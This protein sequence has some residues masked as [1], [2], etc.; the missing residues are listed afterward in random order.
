MRLKTSLT[1]AF[2]AFSTACGDEAA[3]TTLQVADSSGVEVVTNLAGSTEAADLWSLSPQPAVNIGSDHTSGPALSRVTALA[4]LD[5]EEVVVGMTRPPQGLVIG[6]DGTV[7]ATLGRAGDGPGEFSGVASVVPL[8]GDSIAVWDQVRRRMS[9][10]SETGDFGRE[11]DLGPLAPAPLSMV[12]ESGQAYLLAGPD[13]SLVLFGLGVLSPEDGVHRVEA[14]SH[15]VTLDGRSLASFGPFPGVATFTGHQGG[16]WV[17]FGARS[18][19][20]TSGDRLI[21]GTAE[22]TEFAVF[23]PDGRLVR[24]VRWPDHD[25]SVVDAFEEDLSRFV[26]EELTAMPPSAG[27][28]VQTILEEAPRA[29]RYPAYD[30][31][32][33]D[34]NGSVWLAD[35]PGQLALPGVL[36]NRRRMPA[37]RWLVFGPDGAITAAVETPEGFEPYFVRDNAVWGVY[38]DELDVESVRAYQ[39]QK[40]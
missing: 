38:K 4:L 8:T 37:R 26:D 16:G 28:M 30:G 39:I 20:A 3:T 9:V 22:E 35:Y 33:A 31:L 6:S 12:V 27:T 36:P 1:V 11:V 10:F 2:V 17:I 14:E 15:R 34:R 19:G 21:V 32:I 40:P 29:E 25:R 5:T 7:A 24:L 23:D 13:N 18:W